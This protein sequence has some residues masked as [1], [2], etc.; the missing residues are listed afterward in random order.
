MFEVAV[1]NEAPSKVALYNILIYILIK[2]LIQI[3]T[4]YVQ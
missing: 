2:H 1:K 4:N 3:Y